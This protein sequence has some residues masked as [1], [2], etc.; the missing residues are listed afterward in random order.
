MTTAPPRTRFLQLV[1]LTV[2]V[3]VVA[4]VVVALGSQQ[5]PAS[6]AVDSFVGEPAGTFDAVAA[7]HPDPRRLYLVTRGSSTCPAYP[8]SLTWDGDRLVVVTQDR[9]PG[10]PCTEDWVARTHVLTLPKDAPSNTELTTV[11]VDGTTYP[12]AALVAAT[13]RDE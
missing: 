5:G 4:T 3:A 10:V 11:Q 7:Q 13:G 1:W 8:T 12:V 2:V 9:H 6:V